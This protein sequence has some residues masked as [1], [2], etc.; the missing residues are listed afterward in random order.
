MF[1]FD[2]D[3]ARALAENKQLNKDLEWER[4]SHDCT[5]SSMLTE[6]RS[7]GEA[8]A[9]ARQEKQ[10]AEKGWVSV[11]IQLRELKKEVNR[12]K[13]VEE[14]NIRL[15]AQLEEVKEHAEYLRLSKKFNNK[16]GNN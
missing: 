15:K 9:K 14:E 16:D 5:R 3:L 11:S 1:I 7:W 12:L 8:L 13:N 4:M 10:I 2:A 6:R